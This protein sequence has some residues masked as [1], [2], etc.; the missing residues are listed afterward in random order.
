M[1]VKYEGERFP[2]EITAV[3]DDI[4][5]SAMHKSGKNNW[6]WPSPINKILYRKDELFHLLKLLGAVVSFRLL[7]PFEL[8]IETCLYIAL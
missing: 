8:T 4:E 3:S 2:G 5:V 1:V 6:K 7:I